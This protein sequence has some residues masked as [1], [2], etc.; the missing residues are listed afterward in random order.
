[1]TEARLRL[2]RRSKVIAVAAV[3]AL[4]LTTGVGLTGHNDSSAAVRLRP[5][6]APGALPLGLPT[7]DA[8]QVITVVAASTSAASASLQ[9]W[10]KIPGGWRRM[11]PT[12]VSHVASGGLTATPRESDPSTPLGSFPLTQAFGKLPDPGTGLPYFRVT[13]ADWWISQPGPLYNTHQVC[14]VACPFRQDSPNTH[15]VDAVRAYNYAVAID[16]NRS[17][18]VPGAGSAYFLHVTTAGKPTRGCIS[19]P[20]RTMASILRWL[21]TGAHPRILIGIG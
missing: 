20:Q 14:G 19:V 18:A 12:V 5:V 6:G 7:G 4:A 8:E 1:M 17:P 2:R 13:S 15:L 11:G 9:A 21:R 10:A 16:Y 3:A